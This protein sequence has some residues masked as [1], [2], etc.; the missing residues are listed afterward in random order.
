MHS[1]LTNHKTSIGNSSQNP[2]SKLLAGK[3]VELVFQATL[4]TCNPIF[5]VSVIAQRSPNLT[6]PQGRADTAHVWSITA[7]MDGLRD[8]C[9]ELGSRF[10]RPP[11]GG[12]GGGGGGGGGGGVFFGGALLHIYPPPPRANRGFWSFEGGDVAKGL[13]LQMPFLEKFGTIDT[14]GMLFGVECCSEFKWD[15]IFGCNYL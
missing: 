1:T 5:A 7:T 12:A 8:L 9:V 11:P 14:S 15:E 4:S 10:R 3:A 2:G 13:E 6:S